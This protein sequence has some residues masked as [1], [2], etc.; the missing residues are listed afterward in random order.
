MRSH[1][2]RSARSHLW[3]LLVAGLAFLPL[4]ALES[5]LVS[6]VG[7]PVAHFW[8][9]SGA[10]A[11]GTSVRLLS[12]TPGATILFTLDGSLPTA[13][14]PVYRQPI[15]LDSAG[16]GATVVRARLRLAN[17]ELG[18]TATA[19]YF[20][21][22]PDGVAAL[23][24]A[25]DPADLWDGEQGIYANPDQRGHA[26][27][28]PVDMAFLEAG[29]RLG[30]QSPGGVRIHGGWGRRSDKKSFRL[31]FRQEYGLSRLE[32]PLF[33]GGPDSFK[34]LVLHA[35][36]QDSS[37][38]PTNWSLLRN[39]L[40]DELAQASGGYASDNRPVLLFLNSELW[41]VYILRERIDPFFFADNY[42]VVVADY[43]EA[44]EQLGQE[45]VNPESRP[46][47]D[48]LMAFVAS[49]DLADPANYDYVTTQVDVNNF[50]DYHAL[51]IL[52]ANS[53]WPHHNVQQFRPRLQ[54][55]RW[56]WLFWDSDHAFGL[57]PT[58]YETDMLAVALSPTHPHDTDRYTLLLRKLLENPAF[59]DLFLVRLADLLN[60]LTPEMMLT[61]LDNLAARL[62]PVIPYEAG[63]WPLP[64][65]NWPAHIQE[66]RDF[67]Q[68]R[69]VY[70]R[71]H[72]VEHFN[73]P[74]PVP[75]VIA[76]GGAAGTVSV[77][78]HLLDGA[79]GWQG[80]YFYGSTIQVTAIPAPGYRFAG[81]DWEGAAGAGPTLELVMDQDVHLA[82]RFAPLAAGV[83]RPGDVLIEGYGDE[84][85]VLRVIRPGGLDL[86]GWRLTDNDAPTVTDEGSLILTGHPVWA[87]IPAGTTIIIDLGCSRPAAP[88]SPDLDPAGG[89][90]IVPAAEPYVDTTADPWF[91]LG[92]Q[93]N[94]FLLAAGD[95]TPIAHLLIGISDERTYGLWPAYP[96]EL[97]SGG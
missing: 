74:P 72:V 43:L 22:L 60:F 53:D 23:S 32:Y 89:R 94:L 81:W 47:W 37:Q 46:H 1:S 97:A 5:G 78:G 93:D 49:H 34:R 33:S 65:D 38:V 31:Y 2:P 8:P 9:A 70:V 59:V 66:M 44:P 73:L 3:L 16:P 41:G 18:P 12:T 88:C 26:W 62:A 4:L 61:D 20:V 79:A 75:L 51:Q 11:P 27:E 54:G 6:R 10:Y 28:R 56:Q 80:L 90:L 40:A 7:E 92:E 24:L 58:T 50:I 39:A 35:G 21:G 64:G 29:G 30:F 76:P 85:I 52:I 87:D 13:V 96:S 68:Q 25:V 67:V 42:G 55:G 95:Q 36:G 82:A 84:Q 14:S 77:N 69:P 17:G 91:R 19:T 86:R 71:Q 15:R 48:H 83:P 45:T 57:Y 63:R